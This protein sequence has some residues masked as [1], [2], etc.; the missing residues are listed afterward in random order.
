MITLLSRVA[1][2]VLD[3]EYMANLI[4]TATNT[5]SLG[6]LVTAIE[7]AGLIDI[8]KNPGPYTVLAPTDEAFAKLSA[9]TMADWLQDVP[10]LKR[11]LTYH[12]VFGD[13]RSDDLAETDEAP[14]V[15][16][17]IVAVSQADGFK[18]NDAK[19]TKLDILADNG[20]IHVI[21]TVLVP[22]LIAGE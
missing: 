9:N 3:T 14:T 13:V 8:L 16:G 22:A 12:I 11:I 19:V 1:P 10:K 7:T 5:E 2:N 6:T 15:E 4:D 18:V 21:D 17:S 20:V